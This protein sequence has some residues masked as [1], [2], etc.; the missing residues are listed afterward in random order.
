MVVISC[1]TREGGFVKYKFVRNMG[2][3]DRVLRIGFSLLMIYF[4][5]LS[6][7]FITDRAAALILGGMGV[8]NLLAAIIGYC[9]LYRF[10]GFSTC[11]RKTDAVR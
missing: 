10:V 4:G 9:P 2:S 7:Y 3:T 6:S 8:V 1:D 11:T 5:L